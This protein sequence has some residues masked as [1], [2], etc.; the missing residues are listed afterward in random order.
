MIHLGACFLSVLLLFD[1]MRLL[2]SLCTAMLTTLASLPVHAQLMIGQITGLTGPIAASSKESLEGARLYLNHIN[3]K[4]GV[5]GQ[6]I[7]LV[8]MDDKFDPNLSGP[9]ADSLIKQKNVLAMF[10]NRGTEHV[11]TILPILDQAGV[12]LIAPTSG[13]MSLRKPVNRLVFNLRASHQLEAEK[14]ISHL[15]L[16]GVSNIAVVY[17]ADAFGLDVMEGVKRGFESQNL[18]PMAVIKADKQDPAVVPSVVEKLVALGPQSVVWIGASAVVSTGVKA[19]RAAGSTVQVLTL[20]NNASTG[21][22]KQLGPQA[23]GV[24]VTQ[25]LPSERSFAFSVIREAQQLAKAANVNELSPIFLEGFIG[26]KLLVEALRRSGSQPT[27]ESLLKSLNSMRGLDLGGLEISYS[28]DDHTG[29]D[30]VE[31]SIIGS[32]GKFKR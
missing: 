31:L 29:L 18:K 14:I 22:I 23:H 13:S 27:R 25:V 30:F 19:L 26:A 1:L 32:D 9:A 28:P 10:M 21:F 11:E 20:S 15:K 4:G 16:V 17:V 6:K 7:E 5:L 8:V 3:A 24:I 2:I 12:P